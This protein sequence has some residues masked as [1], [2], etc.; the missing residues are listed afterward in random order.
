MDNP[1]ANAWATSDSTTTK[2]E[3]SWEQST[4]DKQS[5]TRPAESVEPAWS[6]PSPTWTADEPTW[7]PP[8][9]Q[10]SK[11]DSELPPVPDPE[12]VGESEADDENIT[13]PATKL[14]DEE[15]EVI[16]VGEPVLEAPPPQSPLPALDSDAFG[17]FEA[18]QW[19][20]DLA[21]TEGED[22]VGESGPVDEW[23][24][25]RQEKAKQDQY[26]PPEVLSAILAELESLSTDFFPEH[27]PN[28]D[29]APKSVARDILEA[30]DG[31][32]AVS[33]KILPT[34]ISLEPIPPLSKSWI[35]KKTA[36]A[37]RL[38]RHTD[39]ARHSS[40]L[41]KYLESKGSTAW[42]ASIKSRPELIH[43][44]SDVLPAGWKVVEAKQETVTPPEMKRKSTSILSTF[45]GRGKASSPVTSARSSPV[46][47][48]RPSI[49]LGKSNSPVT[50]RMSATTKS[51]ISPTHISTPP[52]SPLA[53]STFAESAPSAVATGP[54]PDVFPP[55]PPPP[56]AV[57][58][59]LG[60]FSRT[61]SNNGNPASMALSSDDLDFLSE[62]DSS[63]VVPSALDD[64]DPLE[65]ELFQSRPVKQKLPPPLAPPPAP[66]AI[67][68]PPSRSSQ[69][70]NGA[71]KTMLSPPPVLPLGL[72]T[73]TI[74]SFSGEG[75]SDGSRTPTVST[76][77]S[78]YSVATS[79]QANGGKGFGWVP[80]TSSS[81][82]G[83][84]F[85]IPGTSASSKPD[86][87]PLTT[88][89]T[90]LPPPLP[91]PSNGGR[92]PTPVAVM[93][94]SS[95][96]RPAVSPVL[97]PPPGSGMLPPPPSS[98]ASSSSGSKG[99][100]SPTTLLDLGKSS[101][102]DTLPPLPTESYSASSSIV[103]D[104][105][106]FADFQDSSFSSFRS[107]GGSNVNFSPAHGHNYSISSMSS[108]SET[109]FFGGLGDSSMDSNMSASVSG[110]SVSGDGDSGLSDF[111]DFVS[112]L[113]APPKRSTANVPRLAQMPASTSRAALS[114]PLRSPLVPSRGSSPAQKH[115]IPTSESYHSRTQSLVDSAKEMK[116]WPSS[117]SMASPPSPPSISRQN[118][119]NVSLVSS[120]ISR[121]NTGNSHPISRQNT[122]TT[123]IKPSFPPVVMTATRQNTGTFPVAKMNSNSSRQN[124]T[125]SNPPPMLPAPPGFGPPPGP[126]KSPSPPV[127]LDIF[128]GDDGGFTAKAP[129]TLSPP[130]M[131]KH[132]MLVG[133]DDP[134]DL[135]G[136]N[137]GTSTGSVK[138]TSPPSGPATGRGGL[139]AQDLSFFEG[140]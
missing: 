122:G 7:K 54:S 1:W 86:A 16:T 140:L 81:A 109:S 10:W 37:V 117:S 75:T 82:L 135:F 126:P 36:D 129:N 59:F 64:E 106:D 79:K 73:P 30:V 71:G 29:T 110:S 69:L 102:K 85:E 49:D 57:S 41:A 92:R 124:I 105:D 90:R 89:A 91:P 98:F 119:G 55:E 2:D 47:S 5:W 60:R 18:A 116:S 108:A 127:T 42:E 101:E 43:D 93:S 104:D 99:T 95:A 134:L 62:T 19:G 34:L 115:P 58:R 128:G 25:A 88:P 123:S 51:P 96:N 26:V 46:P 137:I 120:P 22:E 118:T 72:P 15:R 45:F 65:S 14:D 78:G 40:P 107:G 74:T 3:P 130:P 4:A 103:D 112:G 52:I 111:D 23:E 66:V 61:K 68:P 53:V 87:S 84:V 80:P 28:H 121:Q 114:S 24:L 31:L 67:P 33:H 21:D 113:T 125:S 132:T 13:L 8:T 100:R 136:G 56:S 12:T 50:S 138:P 97:A 17:T 32:E 44:D 76:F 6:P 9:P 35:Y 77:S 70:Q 94:S 131:M 133:N 20:D 27:S 83:G 38:T 39:V 48:P 11:S 63:K 139:S